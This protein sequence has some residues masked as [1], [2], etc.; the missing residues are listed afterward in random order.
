[1]PDER[2]HSPLPWSR[3]S[4]FDVV[5]ANG[6]PVITEYA[7]VLAESDVLFILRCV[8]SH[9]ALINVHKAATSL[10]RWVDRTVER[11]ECCPVCARSPH[12]AG[13]A[14]VGALSADRNAE[15]AGA[16]TE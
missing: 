5:D 3:R 6:I 11:G 4:E 2:K 8:N 16:F 10:L 7:G 1:M 14:L 12:M 15:L 13:C 9:K